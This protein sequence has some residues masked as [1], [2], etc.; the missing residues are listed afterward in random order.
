MLSV[1]RKCERMRVLIEECP[2]ITTRLQCLTILITGLDL[3]FLALLAYLRVFILSVAFVDDGDTHA[4]CRSKRENKIGSLKR[5]I[6]TVLVIAS[7]FEIIATKEGRR[8]IHK[9]NN[10]RSRRENGGRTKP[11]RERDE[12]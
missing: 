1:L 6:I 2:P 8:E 3:I 4:I 7:S 9:K 12:R 10:K 5:K 11:E